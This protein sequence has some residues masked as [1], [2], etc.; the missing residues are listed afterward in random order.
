MTGTRG[1][2]EKEIALQHEQQLT[3]RTVKVGELENR[4]AALG[5]EREDL[6]QLLGTR[7][8]LAKSQQEQIAAL[9]QSKEQ[10]QRQAAELEATLNDVDTRKQLELLKTQ[11]EQVERAQHS[12]AWHA[13]ASHALARA[14]CKTALS[15][16][17]VEHTT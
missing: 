2:Q 12:T 8:Q 15:S 1:P 4:L 13:A 9:Q 3:I 10:L 6:Q 14:A 17:H 16:A 7:E 5:K 11:F